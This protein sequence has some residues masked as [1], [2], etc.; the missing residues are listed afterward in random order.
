MKSFRIFVD[1][2]ACCFLLGLLIAFGFGGELDVT[3]VLTLGFL[4]M[5]FQREVHRDFEQ[6]EKSL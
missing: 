6:L 3:S 1:A 4:L 2:T 5:F